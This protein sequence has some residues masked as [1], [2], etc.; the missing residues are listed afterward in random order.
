LFRHA[1]G[2]PSMKRELT[3]PGRRADLGMLG[4]VVRYTMLELDSERRRLV[5]GR[6]PSISLEESAPVELLGRRSLGRSLDVLV[7]GTCRTSGDG[8]QRHH[9]RYPSQNAQSGVGG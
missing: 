5:E 1:D 3:G 9:P 8:Q 7:A 2:D 6:Q 4:E